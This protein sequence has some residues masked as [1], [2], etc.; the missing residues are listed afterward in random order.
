MYLLV[1]RK[2]TLIKTNP[3]AKKPE[4]TTIMSYKIDYY[5]SHSETRDHSVCL[6]FLTCL[7]YLYRICVYFKISY[8]IHLS[9]YLS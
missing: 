7:T 5:F 9:R 2:S 3:L 1:K 4:L 8:T 6:A